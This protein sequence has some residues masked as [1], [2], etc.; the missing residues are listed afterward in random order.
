MTRSTVIPRPTWW[1]T[2]ALRKV[3]AQPCLILH[4]LGVGDARGIVDADMDVL[5]ANAAVVALA[6]EGAGD[7]VAH[8]IELAELDDDVDE[9]AWVL[10]LVAANQLGRLQGAHLV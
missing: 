5:P 4:Y 6:V 3:I 1:A 8:A 9:L 7:A 10:A 2:A